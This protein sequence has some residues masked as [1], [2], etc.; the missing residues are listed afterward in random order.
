[1]M[2][3]R[4]KQLREL[5]DFCRKPITEFP[6]EKIP[7]LQKMLEEI[8]EHDAKLKEMQDK[9]QINEPDDE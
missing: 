2:L 1:M 9:G 5:G 7:D 6:A 4:K 3:R 8:Q